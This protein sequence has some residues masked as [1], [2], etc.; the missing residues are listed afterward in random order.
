MNIANA[1][2]Q[3]EN[4][5]KI[6][7][8]K[9][10]MNHYRIPLVHQRPIFLQG[11]PGLG[12][13]AIMQQISKELNIG[14]VAYSMT[15]HTRQ[16]AIG[17]PMIVEKQY[18][19]KTY[20]VSEYTMSEII[21]SVYECM[22]KTGC[23][24][25]ILF[26]DEINCVSETLSPAMLLFLQYKI[27]GGHKLPDG[28]IVITAGNQSR[29]NKS[30]RDFD[31]ATRDRLKMIVV[32]P[33]YDSWKEYAL[34]K[35][36]LRAVISFLDIRQEHFYVVE[37]TVE[38]F[39][40]VTPRSWEDLS[41][42]IQ[43]YETLAIPA[44]MDLISQYIQNETVARDF[45]IYYELYQKYKK[46]YDVEG[47]LNHTYDEKTMS[48]ARKARLD[49]RITLVGLLLEAVLHDMHMCNVEHDGLKVAK[50][51]LVAYKEELLGEHTGISEIEQLNILKKMQEEVRKQREAALE[52]SR[53]EILTTGLEKMQEMEQAL[54]GGEH[55]FTGCKDFYQVQ[56]EQLKQKIENTQKKVGSLLQFLKEAFGQGNELGLAVND[57]TAAPEAA[58]FIG[59]FLSVDYFEAS[60][61]LQLH[62]REDE[63]LHQIEINL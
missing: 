55:S 17:L 57:L 58:A 62:K 4:A 40:V 46:A 33:D 19:G 25:G 44:D 54:S 53:I 2:K 35:N 30:V 51:Q 12:K 48:E 36:I 41:Q 13:T 43:M 18:G 14:L 28:W 49:E 47:I 10:D 5:V 22:E 16:S 39:S 23:R 56:I 26:L 52:G 61:N 7:L 3:I 50:N 38:G 8:Q 6:Y 27:F 42:S 9:D 60:N 31:A 32:E 34:K 45:S 1:K 15:H 59:Q 63:L 11:A 37:T 29:Y 20:S 21:A 24:E